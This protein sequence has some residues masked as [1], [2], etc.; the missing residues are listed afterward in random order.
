MGH[1]HLCHCRNIEHFCPLFKPIFYL[2]MIINHK[3][4]LKWQ[5][6]S[7]INNLHKPFLTLPF[8]F[9][10]FAI[11]LNVLNYNNAWW[12]SVWT[13]SS[14]VVVQTGAVF[15][16][17]S[18]HHKHV[19]WLE[20]RSCLLCSSSQIQTRHHR[21]QSSQP[22]PGTLEEVMERWEHCL[23]IECYEELWLSLIEFRFSL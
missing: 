21:L 8:T 14:S 12:E 15:L 3:I 23:I 22:Q 4:V 2:Q 17:W 11:H 5:Y 20:I 19:F 18:W 10:F 7:L 9:R 13:C 6:F 16:R 1:T